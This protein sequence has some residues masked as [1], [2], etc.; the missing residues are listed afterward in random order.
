MRRLPLPVAG[1]ALVLALTA[2]LTSC[3]GHHG[4]NGAQGDDAGDDAGGDGAGDD[5]VGVGAD[6]GGDGGFLGDGATTSNCAPGSDLVYVASEERILY[7]YD[8]R[9]NVFTQVANIDCA[10]G[11]YVNSMAV[12]R[13]A[14]AWINYGDGSLW[15]VSTQTPGCVA[16]GFKPNQGGVALFGMGFSAKTSGGN[17]ETLFICDL[18]GGGLGYI[19][20]STM[21][22]ARF[23][24]FAGAYANRAAELTGTGDARLFG[25]FAGSPLGDAS[26]ASV[27]QIDPVT[28]AA[29]QDWPLPTID[30]GSDWAFS[31]WGGDFYL[32]TADKYNMSNPDTTVTRFRPSDGSLTVLSPNIGFR[33]VG[34]GSSTCAP[35][36]TQ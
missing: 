16:T 27:A 25:F 2:L 35:T 8:P 28:E 15:K 3:G 9:Q 22:L 33:I 14:V 32:Y 26:A 20:L 10:G 4:G 5:A 23:G 11:S 7:S 1:A 18:G 29:T 13:D 19:D 6:D 36:T 12:D 17:D 31:F 21:T 24:P 34:A 30:T